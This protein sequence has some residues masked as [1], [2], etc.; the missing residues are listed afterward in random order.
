MRGLSEQAESPLVDDPF[1]LSPK[2]RR[3]PVD[4]PG[5]SHPSVLRAVPEA[6]GP[7]P[8]ASRE[9]WPGAEGLGA[10]AIPDSTICATSLWP[11]LVAAGVDIRTVAERHGHAQATMTLNRY[12]HALPERD[13]AAAAVLGGSFEVG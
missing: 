6:R 8:R 10:L 3:R 2:R 11:A 1:V 5:L 13:R 4:E 7:G 9:G 12:A